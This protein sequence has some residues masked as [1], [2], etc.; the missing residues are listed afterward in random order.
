MVKGSCLCGGVAYETEGPFKLMA[1][2]HCTECRRATGADFAT[3]ATVRE[4]NFELLC[5]QE[6][7]TRYESSPGNYRIFCS[8]CGSPIMKTVDSKPGEVRLRLGLLEGDP[9]VRP[10]AH[11]FVGERAPW[12]QILDALPRFEGLPAKPKG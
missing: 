7:L 8:R 5:G 2:C 12:T 9:G 6:L 3:N 10:V 1:H 11:V 4:A